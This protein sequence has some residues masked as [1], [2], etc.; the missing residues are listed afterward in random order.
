[1]NNLTKKNKTRSS[2]WSFEDCLFL[3]C[4]IHPA[5]VTGLVL[6]ACISYTPST[7]ENN[8]PIPQNANPT[9][10]FNQ[11]EVNAKDS[12]DLPSENLSAVNNIVVSRGLVAAP[13]K[14]YFPR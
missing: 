8:R 10:I 11:L 2:N 4:S 13:K 7:P 14:N 12:F 6:Y 5:S 9:E 3:L 1:M